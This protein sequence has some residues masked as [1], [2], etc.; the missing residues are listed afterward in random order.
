MIDHGHH[1]L[2]L[3]G[4]P[5]AGTTTAAAALAA[6]PGSPKVHLHADDFWHVI[7]HGAIPPYLPEA[8]DQNGVVMQALA[9]AASAYARGGYLTI[10]DGIVGPWFLAPFRALTVPVHYV[11]L[12][13]GLDAAITRC[14][15]RGGET[16]TDPAV[17]AA[18]HG[19]FGALGPL[20][21]HVLDVTGLDRGQT[22][23]AAC[24]A[25]DGGGF[26]LGN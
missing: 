22:L 12:R 19:Q 3:T 8:H 4:P 10:L 26:L 21:G 18:L 7:K 24:A 2:I 5:G 14:R 17:I 1:I 6:M 16:L 23:A 11:V 25:L 20:E 9:D 15:A 13:P